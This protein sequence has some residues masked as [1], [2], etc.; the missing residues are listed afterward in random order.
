MQEKKLTAASRV[1]DS[2]KIAL[3]YELGKDF[4]SRDR[5]LRK[6]LT[7]HPSL[8]KSFKELEPVLF[9]ALN[10]AECFRPLS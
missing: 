1:E 2:L 9:N 8:K 4:Q 7:A 5:I 3:L 6:A 10:D